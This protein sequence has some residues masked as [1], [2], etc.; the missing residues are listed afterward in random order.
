MSASNLSNPPIFPKRTPH[1]WV[2]QGWAPTTVNTQPSRIGGSLG[3]SWFRCA[4]CGLKWDLARKADSHRSLPTEKEL[5]RG[6]NDPNA[7]LF[8]E[9]VPDLSCDTWLVQEVMEA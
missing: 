8:G 4:R 5:E 1:E 9:S 6:S 2:F 7:E 3:T